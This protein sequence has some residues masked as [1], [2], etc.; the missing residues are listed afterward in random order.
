MLLNISIH[1]LNM[2]DIRLT[3]ENNLDIIS[4]AKKDL[5]IEIIT[6]KRKL[7][8]EK[9]LDK[10]IERYNKDDFD[11]CITSARTCVEEALINIFKIVKGIELENEGDLIKLNKKVINTLNLDPSKKDLNDCL[12]Q[13]ISGLIS[14]IA[15]FSGLRNKIGDAHATK[16]EAEKHHA[17]LV[18][19]VSVAYINFLFDTYYYQMEKGFIN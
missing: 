4:L 2:T 18:L 7:K 14:I 15:G 6:E 11:G 13:V 3:K 17:K 1:F 8:Y 19:N 16:Y 9:I 5:E 12:K 10:C